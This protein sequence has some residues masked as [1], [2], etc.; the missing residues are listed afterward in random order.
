MSVETRSYHKK[1][2][3]KVFTVVV[4]EAESAKETAEQKIRKLINVE[5]DRQIAE[6]RHRE[7]NTKTSFEG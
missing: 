3:N 5:C 6:K 1:I 2:D 7:L 4:E